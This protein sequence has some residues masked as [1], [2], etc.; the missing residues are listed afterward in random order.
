MKIS[1][2]PIDVEELNKGDV[3][4]SSRIEEITGER[5][6][7]DAYQFGKM[8]LAAFIE[9]EREQCGNPVVVK[10]EQDGLRILTDDE[11]VDYTEKRFK[12][13][14]RAAGRAHYRQSAYIDSETLSGGA[15][16]KHERNIIVNSRILQAM[17]QARVGGE[18]RRQ[19]LKESC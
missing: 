12:E 17:R 3:I 2:W 4:P 19:M 7:S 18:R 1:K 15:R 11:A 9:V 14:L 16:E 10:H 13:A 5:C 8:R 6:G